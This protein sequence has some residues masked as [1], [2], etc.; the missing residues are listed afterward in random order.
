M[1]RWPYPRTSF[2]PPIFTIA[3]AASALALLATG[4]SSGGSRRAANVASSTTAT[5]TTT[6]NGTTT[7]QIGSLAGALAFARCMRSHGI[8][9][10]PDPT[11][12]G[13]FDK[14]KLRQLDLSVS[15]VRAIEDRSCRYDFENGGQ[16]QRQTITPADQ[17]DYVKG[18][19]CMRSHGVPDFP[20]PTF[21]NNTVRFNIPSS[22]DTDS[23]RFK[24]AAATCV[25]L[26]P[27]GLPYSN[28]SAP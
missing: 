2:A 21:Q 18:A 14:S 12:S 10:F 24:R 4:C 22:I 17:A 19:A 8:P 26:I 3:A 15:R 6:H 1:T 20:D 13:V 7:V 9:N 27:A 11:S 5:T 23:S 16:P 28:S 25:K